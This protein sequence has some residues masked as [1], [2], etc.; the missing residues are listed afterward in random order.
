MAPLQV[1][2]KIKFTFLFSFKA[3]VK[4]ISLPNVGSNAQIASKK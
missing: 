1:P 2:K 3:N 4:S